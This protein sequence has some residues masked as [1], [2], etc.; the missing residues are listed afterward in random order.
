MKLT[1]RPEWRPRPLSSA[2]GF[3]DLKIAVTVVLLFA[4]LNKVAGVYGL[5]AVLTGAGGSAAQLSL[6][7]YSVLGLV[8]LGWGIKAVSQENPKHSL[9]FAHI[10]FADHIIS[11][12]WLV[13]FAVVWWVYTPHDGRRQANSAAQEEMM[14][15]TNGAHRN[16][17]EEEREA[18]AMIIWSEEKGLATAVIVL[19]WVAKFYFAMLLYSYAIH[20]RKGSYRSLPCSRPSPTLAATSFSGLPDDDDDVEDFYRLPIRAPPQPQSHS[21]QSSLTHASS[22]SQTSF[23][24]FVSAP[25]SGRPRRGKPGKSNLSISL[26]ASN[27]SMK[28]SDTNEVDEV[29]F[30]DD[31]RLRAGTSAEDS[32]SVDS[33]DD[34]QGRS[35]PHNR[36][37]SRNSSRA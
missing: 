12:A 4:V 36:R 20:L 33:L 11:S 29:L 37:F 27:G 1:L 23:A 9:Y 13:F 34:N 5:V 18:A 35:T 17:T 7:I 26:S 15:S 25:P 24:D 22:P 19:G 8:A 10:F 16:M 21:R 28:G 32:I 3:L 30:D 6:Y 2:F 31:E 14:N